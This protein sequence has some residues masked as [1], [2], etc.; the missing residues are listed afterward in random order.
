[1]N[2]GNSLGNSSAQKS[3]FSKSNSLSQVVSEYD[4]NKLPPRTSRAVDGKEETLL[5]P[6]DENDYLEVINSM[7]PM[8]D[9]PLTFRLPYY[10]FAYHY[11]WVSELNLILMIKYL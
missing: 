11:I 8:H 4:S 7:K 1:M 6:Y 5:Y 2:V 3:S 10:G 9:Q